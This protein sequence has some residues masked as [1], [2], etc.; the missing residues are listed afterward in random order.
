M[1][2]EGTLIEEPSRLKSFTVSFSSA[3]CI[4]LSLFCNNS[5]GWLHFEL[6]LAR[7]V[8]NWN[9]SWVELYRCCLCTK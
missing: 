6:A 2:G 4:F 3:N 5:M 7:T 9:C 8:I 1:G